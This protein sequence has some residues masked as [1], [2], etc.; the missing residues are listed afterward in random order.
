MRVVY[1]AYAVNYRLDVLPPIFRTMEMIGDFEKL[2][3][4]GRLS[5]LSR[6]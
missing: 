1:V 4:F 6:M 5:M 2:S 3:L